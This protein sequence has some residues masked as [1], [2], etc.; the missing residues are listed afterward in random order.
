MFYKNYRCLNFF[1][2]IKEEYYDVFKDFLKYFERNYFKSDKFKH[3]SFNNNNLM[4]LSIS[5][6]IKF[7]TNNMF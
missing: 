6:N 3:F 7:Y 4:S 5:E 1:N 2:K